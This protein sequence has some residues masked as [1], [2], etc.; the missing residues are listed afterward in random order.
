MIAFDV[1]IDGVATVV[2]GA[3]ELKV[4]VLALGCN[5]Q[6][7]LMNPARQRRGLVA[8]PVFDL[9][10]TGTVPGADGQQGASVHWLEGLALRA[11]QTV[12]ITIIDTL[13][14]DPALPAPAVVRQEKS[15]RE[16]FEHCKR[17]YLAMKDKYNG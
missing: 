13:Q 2:A 7:E 3:G 4:L 10:V 15:E 14:A 11:G 5:P 9:S 17:V 16:H 6:A 1:M 8:Q 12:S